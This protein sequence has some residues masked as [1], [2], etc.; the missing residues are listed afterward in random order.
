MKSQEAI[1]HRLEKLRT[2]YLRSHCALVRDKKP[3][4]CVYNYEHKPFGVREKGVPIEYELAPRVSISLVVIQPDRPVRL[5]TYGSEKPDT[6]NGDLCDQDDIA[7]KCK[8]FKHRVSEEGAIQSFNDLM[9][10]DP[11]VLEN[12]RDIAALQWVLGERVATMPLSWFDRILLFFDAVVS[13]IF[14]Q[15]G[16]AASA[17]LEQIPENLWSNADD[18]NSGK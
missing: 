12:Y 6:W 2:R 11:Y 5:C 15:K 18:E 8:K 7:R 17:E 1:R 16:V 3:Q 4:N 13:R 10:D 14:R 9:L